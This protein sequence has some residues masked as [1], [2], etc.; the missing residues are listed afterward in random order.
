MR[1]RESEKAAC[2]AS[3]TRQRDLICL[4]S[5]CAYAYTLCL[6]HRTTLPP[7]TKT[8]VPNTRK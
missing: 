7:S 4:C 3:K 1:Q 5:V 8:N 6:Y 2:D